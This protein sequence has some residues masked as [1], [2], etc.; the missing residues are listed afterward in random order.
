M[1]ARPT[2][3]LFLQAGV[4]TGRTVTKNCALV[5]NPQT[6]RFCEVRQPF[7]ANYRVSGGYT[8]PW[9]LQVSGVFQSI[10]TDPV[11]TIANYPARNADAA[12]SLG[13]PIANPGGVI[14]VPLIDPSTYTDFA[15][16][17]NQVDLR[18]TKGLRVGRYRVDAL[19]DFY[20]AF[21]VS[22]VLTYTTTYGPAWLA[23]TGILQSGYLKLGGR[24]TF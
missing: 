22:P 10:P 20:N 8:F 1:N 5:D 18:L 7:L 23:P 6:L 16:R 21:N 13:R 15:D 17:V 14:N 9:Q 19:A 12:S 3:R 2:G 24:L 11:A 4:S